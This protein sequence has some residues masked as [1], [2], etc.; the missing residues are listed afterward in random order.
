[1]SLKQ[2]LLERL[3]NVKPNH[4]GYRKA[5]DA[6]SEIQKLRRE[7][8]EALAERT[9]LLDRIAGQKRR[10]ETLESELSVINE[11]HAAEAA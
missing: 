3:A 2:D 6:L 11:R 1:M 10:I 9:S 7:R 5:Q 8:D 4:G